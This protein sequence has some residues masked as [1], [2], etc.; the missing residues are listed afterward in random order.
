MKIY[1]SFDGISIVGFLST[2]ILAIETNEIQDGAGLWRWHV[3]T[4]LLHVMACSR[5]GILNN[6]F[7]KVG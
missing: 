2:S 6:A 1:N 5:P 7:V 4:N 3:A